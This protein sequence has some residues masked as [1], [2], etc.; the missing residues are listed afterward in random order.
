MRVLVAFGARP[1][2]MKVAPV[3]R[4]M[5]SRPGFD[6]ILLNT[7]QHFSKEMSSDFVDALELPA[8]DINLGIAEGSQ[9]AQVAEI[10]ARLEP[11]MIDL[12]PDLTVVVGDVSSTLAAGLTSSM[13]E[14]PVAHIEAGLRS[15]D[16]RMPEERNRVLVDQLSRYLFTTSPDADDNLASEGIESER[17]FHVGNVMIDSLDWVLP[18]IRKLGLPE[19]LR[20]EPGNYGVVTLHRP[21]NVDDPIVLEGIVDA[22][23]DVSDRLPLVF[24][25]HPR[26][27]ARLDGH[28]ERLEGSGIRMVGPQSYLSFMALLEGAR[29]VLTDSGGIQEEATVLGV[30][31][32]TLREN[33]E[34]PIT[35]G[36]GVNELVGTNTADIVRSALRRI[37]GDRPE[38][39]RPH[40]WDG[41]A[42][43]R[44][45]EV[46][47][48]PAPNWP[49]ASHKL[50]VH[51]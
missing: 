41:R 48:G 33:T 26:T 6:P 5:L 11:V 30:P 34:R 27:A 44:I 49:I 1:N 39:H 20:L 8:P 23:L 50:E 42:A 31:C 18:R 16:W 22:L 14:V 19:E 24:P 43:G 37:E 4:A 21:S 7:G 47:E 46:L 15:R 40:G 32:L 2:F 9:S 12:K 29:L 17:V 36:T 38:P 3:Y 25:V 51:V 10:M 35:L 13:L 28:E 45:V